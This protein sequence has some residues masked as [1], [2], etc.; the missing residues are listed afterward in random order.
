MA[1]WHC[2]LQVE[3][4]DWIIMVVKNWHDDP[5]LNCMPTIVLKDYMKVECA[6]VEKN[7]DLIEKINFF[8]Q[9][10]VDD[11]YVNQMG[12]LFYC[13]LS[14]NLQFDCFSSL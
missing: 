11:D 9:L 12:I 10:E 5:Q 6:L 2:H 13:F 4:L 3:N 7:Y 1:L 14:Q 8:E